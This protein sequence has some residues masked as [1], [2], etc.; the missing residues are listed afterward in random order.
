[1]S[2]RTFRA[3]LVIAAAL[4]IVATACAPATT[5]GGASPAATSAPTSAA[6]TA[7]PGPTKGGTLIFAMW[8][9]PTTLAPQ[10]A[11]QT[12]AGL[13]GQVV[14]E[15]LATT[16]PDGNYVAVL[17]KAIPTVQN[18]GVKVS[19]DGK[20]MSVT[21]E[22]L[23][24]VKWSDGKPFTSADVKFTWE[25]RLKDPK[26]VSR[27]GYSDIESV[28]TPGETTVVLNYKTIHGPYPTTFGSI[29]PK[30]ILDG[31]ADPSQTEYSRK[32]LGTGP[33]RVTEFKA[34]DSITVEKN[35]NYRFAPEKPYLDKI[36]FKSV[37]SSQVAIAQLKAGEVHGMWNLLESETPDIE[38]DSS[39]KIA[40]SPSNNVERIE[41]N[42]AENKD[43]SDPKVPH[44]ILGDVKVRRALIHATPKQQI[45]DKLL[46]GKATV[47]SSVSPRGWAADKTIVQEAY[48]PKKADE[49]LDQAGWVK[50]ADGIRA[51]GGARLSL[52]INTTTGNKTREQV[53]QVLVDEWKQRGIE[54]KIQ[55][56]PSAVLLS[57]SWD[58]KDPR[59]RGN[60]DL[61][62]YTT[63][64][65]VDPGLH[66]SQRYTTAQ[67]PTA[68]NKSG[69][70]RMRASDP[71][72]DKLIAEA[73]SS[74]DI[75]K[76][77]GLYR[78][79]YRKINELAPAIWLYE[80]GRIDAHRLNVNGWKPHAWDNITWNTE[81][82]WLKR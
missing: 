19:A 14:W 56:M 21:W 32:P 46:F 37:P 41:I 29:L 24:G 9:E 10:Y 23:P 58:D 18:G 79:I 13:V 55:N 36:V 38:K 64:A 30:H 3:C 78:Q 59:Q 48:D 70:N 5:P 52:T 76:R 53:E 25:S 67:I 11:N 74:L 27:F 81:E 50:G 44:A 45:V 54:L 35:P 80:R 72:M 75:E 71:E 61:A 26:V 6:A 15:G 2:W 42:L 39:L 68:Q 69:Q 47:G 1:M 8:Q 7:T 4:S 33:F 22:L 17:A 77:K 16:D 49:L 65:G 66:M 12:I 31:V 51:K 63:S 73:G 57:G 82:W 60:Y 40:F 62:L 28:D 20:K 43:P 34:G